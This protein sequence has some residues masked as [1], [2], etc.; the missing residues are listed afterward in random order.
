MG[1]SQIDLQDLRHSAGN[2]LFFGSFYELQE[3]EFVQGMTSLMED[4]TTLYE[5]MMRDIFGLGAVLHKKF[6]LLQIAYN[7]FMIAL[8]LGVTSFIAVFIW[9]FVQAP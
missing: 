3:S 8:I 7:S 2:I 5:S 4:K 9:I 1:S 6:V